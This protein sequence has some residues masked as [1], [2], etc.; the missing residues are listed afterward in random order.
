MRPSLSHV[1]LSPIPFA[2][3]WIAAAVGWSWA[4]AVA[5]A[6]YWLGREL[7]QSMRPSDPTR[8]VWTWTNTR[9]VVQPVAAAVAVAAAITLIF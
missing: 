1:L 6:A 9:N 3:G 8:I 5:V 7:A 4:G 2:L